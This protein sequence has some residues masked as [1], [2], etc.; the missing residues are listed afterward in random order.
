MNAMPGQ[1]L[2]GNTV[3]RLSAVVEAMQRATI[4]ALMLMLFS[5][6]AQ[7]AVPGPPLE[8]FFR[9][10]KFSAAALSPNGQYLA[11]IAP[12]NGRQNLVVVDLKSKSS[13]AVTAFAAADAVNPR[14]VNNKRLVYSTVDFQAGLGEQRGGGLYA[15][16]RD[17][18]NPREI[19]PSVG[20][21]I[22]KNHM[23]RRYTEML[24]RIEGESDEVFA[25]SNDRSERYVDVYRLNTRT[26]AR[27]LL[28]YDAPGG[29]QSWVVDRDGVP[30]AAVQVEKAEIAKLWVRRNATAPWKMVHQ[31]NLKES[32]GITPLAFDWTGALFVSARD[33]NDDKAAIY[34]LNLETGALGP[35]VAASLQYDV[36]GG[37]IFDSVQ[38]KLVGVA[39]DG[40]KPDYLWLDPQWSRWHGT[41][42]ATL[43]DRVN[44]LSRTTDANTIL[45][46][47][48]S[49]KV[50]SEY[51]LFDPL[52]RTLEEIGS[53]LPWLKT[54]QMGEREFR[55]YE[56]R[57]G[58]SIPSYVTYP[59]KAERKM[60]P[61]VVDV[62]GGPWVRGNRWEY[63]ANA[64]FLASR[65]YA[66]LQPN[67]R[68]TTGNGWHHY[69]SS[70]KQ[71]GLTMQDDIADGVRHLVSK[72]IVD[73]K[74]VCI[75]GASYGGYATLMALVKEPN[76]FK[77]GISVVGVTDPA[78]LLT[79]SWSDISDTDFTRFR[80]ADMIGDPDKD[81][82]AMERI[83]P[84]KRAGE[85]KAPVLMA[86]GGEDYRVPL[87]HGERMR[88]ALLANKVPVEWVVYREE[89]HGWLKEENRFDFAR[90]LEAFLA[91]HLGR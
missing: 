13:V 35:R 84:L 40:D 3:R 70:W 71:W 12:V 69:R 74:R 9:H 91:T 63:D 5:A 31:A 45:V 68:G 37:L 17:G 1:G 43:P 76:M 50:A 25:V 15:I 7:A 27:Q 34:T 44:L 41:L 88:D 51:F 26:G 77:C 52:K 75:M 47:S 81:K 2:T 48:T 30:R 36:A 83:S 19:S 66:V 10:P 55:R 67:F 42:N 85:I 32:D 22:G 28:T 11:A 65:G 87:V 21:L 82:A 18:Q 24:A 79:V 56:S 73:P 53:S 54:D 23:V 29:V 14:W 16:D 59:V 86:Y 90:R 8:G 58:I 33:A 4:T 20:S 72:G 38:K 62:H 6:A 80:L 89:G 49:D 60:L 78:L 64:Q 39:I 46:R 61:L 57:D